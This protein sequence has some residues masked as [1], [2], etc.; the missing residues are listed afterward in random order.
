MPPPLW[1]SLKKTSLPVLLYGTGDGADKICGACES[2]GIPVA[3]FFASDGFVRKRLFRGKRVLS[4]TE[5]L[6]QYGDFVILLAFGTSL[7]HL[8][9]EIR[10]LA[11]QHQLY[12]P[13]LPVVNDSPTFTAEFYNHHKSDFATARQLFADQQSQQLFD[14]IL[15]YKLSGRI[16]Y[17]NDTIAPTQVWDRLCR[18]RYHVCADLGAYNGDTAREMLEFC[19]NVEQI[20][21]LE[22]DRKNFSKLEAWV[23]QS[24][25]GEIVRPINAA[26]WD[27]D[28]MLPFAHSG[29]RSSR[30]QPS[31]GTVNA[32]SLDRLLDGKT[33]DYIKY[34]VE[35]AEE[36]ALLGS[37][38]TIAIHAP[39]LLVAAY[40][41]SDD[42]F[43][44]PQLINRLNSNYKLR[45]HRN[46]CLPAWDLSI[47]A[48]TQ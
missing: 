46:D 19:P 13:D 11:S 43:R 31:I 23:E 7:P 9:T 28:T 29:N 40:H 36:R 4:Y 45:L 1:Q 20:I 34:D 12:A 8:L 3:D 35:G 26:A 6:E 17:L 47:T 39:D 21:A 38:K 32:V 16:D 41:R 44:L 42:L 25:I 5:A 24:S 14:D 22:P 33:V 37:A 10:K 30:H 27:C 15:A 2:F 48:T 18:S